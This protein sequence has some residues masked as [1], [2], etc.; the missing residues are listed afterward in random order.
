MTIRPLADGDHAEWLRMRVTLWPES[1]DDPPEELRQW[2]GGS[3]TKAVFVAARD[4][5]GLCGFLEVG[6]REH[7]DGCASSPVGYLEGWYVDPDARRAGVGRA[8]VAAGEAWA[9][10]LG[11][12]EMGSDAHVDNLDSHRAHAALGYR[13]TERLVIFA[14][15][16]TRE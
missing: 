10:A 1:V 15:R 7:A 8:L 14:R 4:G 5:G 11:C 3:P 6:L 13:E 12:S 16:L 2:S 9:R